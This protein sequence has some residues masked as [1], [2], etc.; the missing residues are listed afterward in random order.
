MNKK[1]KKKKQYK[2]S[3]VYLSKNKKNIVYRLKW[4]HCYILKEEEIF[5]LKKKY[6]KKKK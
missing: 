2:E 1:R 3:I 6:W 5:I 4:I